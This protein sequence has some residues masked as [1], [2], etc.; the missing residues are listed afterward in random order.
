M[1]YFA[2]LKQLYR[3]MFKN[4]KAPGVS[5]E[6]YPHSMGM[7]QYFGVALRSVVSSSI[8]GRGIE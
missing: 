4:F 6:I 7:S 3:E 5:I 2:F 8:S 1:Q